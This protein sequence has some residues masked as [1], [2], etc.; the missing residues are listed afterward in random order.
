MQALIRAIFTVDDRSEVVKSDGG[1]SFMNRSSKD[2][3]IEFASR[4]GA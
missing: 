1:A 4:G 3:V 2:S